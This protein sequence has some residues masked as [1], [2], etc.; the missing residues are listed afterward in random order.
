MELH[1]VFLSVIWQAS[2]GKYKQNEVDNFFGTLFQSV[3]SS[4]IIFFYYRWTHQQTKNYRQEFYQWS[5]SVYDSIGKLIADGIIVQ[6]PIK[7]F[8]G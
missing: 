1:T 8:I 2:Q 3:N 6:I 4:I 7:N 5:I